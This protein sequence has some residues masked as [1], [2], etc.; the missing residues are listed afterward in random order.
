MEKLWI[1]NRIKR[2]W[3]D[4]Q[5]MVLVFSIMVLIMITIWGAATLTLSTNEYKISNS[6]KK[7]VQAYY[8]AEA[9]LEE[10][11][12]KIRNNEFFGEFP[13]NLETGS[14]LVSRSG[15][16][17]GLIT[18]TSIGKADDFQKT[19]SAKL[20]ITAVGGPP[21]YE[22]AEYRSWGD[23]CLDEKKI[24][25]DIYAGG[26]LTSRSNI[27]IEGDIYTGENADFNTNSIIIGNIFVDGNLVFNNNTLIK[28]NVFVKGDIVFHN[29]TQ[30]IGN[31]YVMGN[32]NYHK[33][34][35]I[36]GN[37]YDSWD[38]AYPEL[39]YDLKLKDLY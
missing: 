17:P 18:L 1:L 2:I 38:G 34:L 29:H 11:I 4:Q 12:A 9:G 22:E 15:S 32:L 3:K 10:G 39:A 24:I 36:T 5:G 23:L 27:E 8:L 7:A 31:I 26:A 19:L 25:G 28:G 37:I 33:E 20:Q 16:I 14:Y 13:G 6:S 30:I 35:L 21:T